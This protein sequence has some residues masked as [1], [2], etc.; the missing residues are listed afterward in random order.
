MA[1]PSMGIDSNTAQIALRGGGLYLE[2]KRHAQS[3][4]LDGSFLK[5]PLWN[6]VHIIYF[7]IFFRR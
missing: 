3:V 1:P 4:S 6:C 7:D 2:A 5:L